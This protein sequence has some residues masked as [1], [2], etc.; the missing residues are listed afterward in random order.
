MAFV[1]GLAL[2]TEG[3]TDQVFLAPIIRRLAE[4]LLQIYIS[5]KEPDREIVL[6]SVRDLYTLGRGFDGNIY[7]RLRGAAP[8]GAQQ[9]ELI[10]VHGDGAGDWN[11]MRTNVIQPKIDAISEVMDSEARYVRVIP[12]REME[13]W[14]IADGEAL[15]RAYK[16]TIGDNELQIPRPARTVER[17]LDPKACLREIGET[18]LGR[19]R[20]RALGVP[21]FLSL[22]GEHAA[23]TTLRNIPSFARFYEEMKVAL[24]EI[25]SIMLHDEGAARAPDANL[26]PPES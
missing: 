9:Y 13:A 2:S 1:L 6:T 23:F 4:E 19:R 24:E 5:V 26:Q 8:I 3:P 12:I 18:C 7:N 16:V 20:A 11:A 10:F 25:I 22:I 15:R 14:A 17:V 21:V